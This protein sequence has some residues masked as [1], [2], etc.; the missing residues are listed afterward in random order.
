MLVGVLGQFSCPSGD[1]GTSTLPQLGIG[2]RSVLPLMRLRRATAPQPN[3]P[4]MFWWYA[5]TGMKTS[6]ERRFELRRRVPHQLADVAGDV[7]RH[8]YWVGSQPLHDEPVRPR[9]DQGV[10]L[11][12][13][14]VR[15]GGVT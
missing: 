15:L 5:G 12:Q 11:V 2:R 3:S 7:R 9:A 13:G 14:A 8:R 10:R 6:R 4:A 1:I